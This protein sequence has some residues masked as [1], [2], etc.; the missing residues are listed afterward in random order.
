MDE[1]VFELSKRVGDAVVCVRG[2][3]TGII[4]CW[5]EPPTIDAEEYVAQIL[6]KYHI[7]YTRHGDEI[8]MA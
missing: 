2:Y 4:K 1:L 6:D 3:K 5:A 8:R 7:P